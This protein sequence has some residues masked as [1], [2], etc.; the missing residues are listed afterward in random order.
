MT[1]Q[2]HR[3]ESV[4]RPQSG[5]LAQIGSRKQLQ[6]FNDTGGIAVSFDV[7]RAIPP[8]IH[9]S[10]CQDDR[11]ALWHTHAPSG[12]VSQPKFNADLVTVRIVTGGHI[13]YRHRAGDFLGAP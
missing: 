8:E 9:I 5:F 10:G 3:D 6:S 12:F 7:V 2:A 4:W 13:L 11:L 1:T